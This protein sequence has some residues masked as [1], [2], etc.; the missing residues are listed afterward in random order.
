MIKWNCNFNIIDSTIQTS[1]AMIII[2]KFQ[3]RA[4]NCKVYV[5][6]MDESMEILIKSYE[7]I[8]EGI[9]N[10]EYEIYPILLNDFVD[11]EIV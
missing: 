3:N 5:K 6:I 10:D 9:F 8:I 4:T 11:A 1:T 2:D 7:Q